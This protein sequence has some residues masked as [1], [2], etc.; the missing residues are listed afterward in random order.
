MTSYFKSGIAHAK[1]KMEK[2][3]QKSDQSD[4]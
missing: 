1:S 3:T 2:K 4:H